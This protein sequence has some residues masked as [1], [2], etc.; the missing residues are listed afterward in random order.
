MGLFAKK[1]KRRF[2]HVFFVDGLNFYPLNM[3]ATLI[4]DNDKDCLVIESKNNEGPTVNIKYNQI[5]SSNIVTKTEIIEKNKSSVGRAMVGGVLLGSLGAVIGG[6][7]GVGNK[8]DNID[9]YYIVINYKSQ[10]EE[11]IKIISFEITGLT[12]WNSFIKELKSKI[13]NREFSEEIYL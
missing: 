5:V 10:G 13:P 2:I 12:N 8:V 3:P 6:M 4:L 1:E 7:S 11:E 9:R